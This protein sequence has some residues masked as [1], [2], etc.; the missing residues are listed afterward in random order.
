MDYADLDLI[1]RTAAGDRA[2]FAGLYD[3]YAA[4]ALGLVVRILR[5]RT[6]A[7]DVLQE[8]FLQVWAQAA[9]FDPAR[10]ALDVWLLLIARSRALDRLRKRVAAPAA[11]LPDRPAADDPAGGLERAEQ[12]GQLRS[13][14]DGLPPEQRESIRLAFFHGLTHEQIARQLNLPLGTVKTR[15]R[16][17][18]HRLRD[19]LAR[20]HAAE[21]A[22]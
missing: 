20:T 16:L 18:M 4:R 6:E 15:I 9:R 12:A 3:R 10:S 22:P 21:A 7:D 2:A 11:E 19:R 1:R 13:A 14:L 17:G 8:V 5:N